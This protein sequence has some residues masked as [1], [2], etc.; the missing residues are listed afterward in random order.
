[1]VTQIYKIRSEIWA[2]LS[3][4]K[5][6]GP[7]KH[8]NFSAILHNFTTD[9]DYIQNTTRHRQSESRT[10]NYGHSHTGKLNSVYFGPQMAKNW[11]RVLTHQT[12][13][14]R[15]GIAMLQGL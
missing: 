12:G 1:M 13:G 4:P 10:A 8:K 6:G 11:T 3:A 7:K 5:F 2:A 15:L 9:H 14:I